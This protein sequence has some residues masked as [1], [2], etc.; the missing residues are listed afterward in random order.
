MYNPHHTTHCI[1]YINHI[2][3]IIILINNYLNLKQY[4]Y[5]NHWAEGL[6]QW[7]RQDEIFGGSMSLV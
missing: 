4:Y 5:K 6:F 2:M 1:I 3:Y 7:I